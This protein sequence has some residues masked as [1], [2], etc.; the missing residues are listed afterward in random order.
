MD[1]Y[2]KNKSTDC[3]IYSE[4][5]SK[6]KVHREMFGQTDFLREILS[7][8]KE[9]CCGSIEVFCPCSKEEL[10]HLVNFLYDGEIHCK[11]ESESLKI[12]E[13]LQKIFGFHRNLGLIYSNE[14][15]F[16]SDNN[17]EAITVTDE[18]I[19]DNS[20]VQ[21][22]V[23]IPV[24]EEPFDQGE[25]IYTKQGENDNDLQC[26]NEN[27]NLGNTT[28][29]DFKNGSKF[30][31]GTSDKKA[32]KEANE[33]A[34]IVAEEKAKREAEEK[35]KQK[36]G[37]KAKIEA[38]KKAKIEAEENREY[39]ANREAEKKAKL[40]AEEKAKKKA[41]IEADEMAQREAGTAVER[42]VKSVQ[43]K[44][45]SLTCQYCGKSFVSKQSVKMH[46]DAIH[47]QLRPFSCDYCE[48]TF[49]QKSNLKT[50]VK[51]KH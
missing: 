47:F 29:E 35:A 26:Y 33:K 41:K 40:V 11:E 22:I 48:E 1:L 3:I 15:L 44:I 34:K 5:G 7:S 2:L 4:D 27:H 50:H 32:K 36:A 24:K 13:N 20:E 17:I 28:A 49:T 37:K 25:D 9:H 14:A 39:E 10:S 45:R 18:N 51:N 46:I 23:I 38:E 19:L 12:I 30:E 8:T 31:H 43:L 42:H 16:I 6:F 21:E